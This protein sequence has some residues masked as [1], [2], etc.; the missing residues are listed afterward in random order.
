MPSAGAASVSTRESADLRDEV[1]LVG[2]R[3]CRLLSSSTE[4]DLLWR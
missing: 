2:F 1:G 4:G 3:D